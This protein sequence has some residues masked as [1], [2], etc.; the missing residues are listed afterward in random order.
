M[1]C[2]DPNHRPPF[3]DR[4]LLGPDPDDKAPAEFERAQ[5]IFF[6]DCAVCEPGGRP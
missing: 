1:T 5:R 4:D 2:S 6:A 3:P